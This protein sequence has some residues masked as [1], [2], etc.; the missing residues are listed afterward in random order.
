MKKKLITVI[1]SFGI[2]ASLLAGCSAPEKLM[3]S[4]KAQESASKLDDIKEE[5]SATDLLLENADTVKENES[6]EDLTQDSEEIVESDTAEEETVENV[7]SS[8]ILPTFKIAEKKYFKRYEGDAVFDESNKDSVD[9]AKGSLFEGTYQYLLMDEK[10]KDAY[11]RLYDAIN[12]ESKDMM[13]KDDVVE[14]LSAELL[15]I[16]PE[17]TGISDFMNLTEAE[18]EKEYTVKENIVGKN[19]IIATLTNSQ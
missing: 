15:G 6:A 4:D 10:C 19:N 3:S 1:L 5:G 14:I 12:I 8:Q 2:S 16:I 13:S 9:Y 11:P 7:V 18:I 17:D